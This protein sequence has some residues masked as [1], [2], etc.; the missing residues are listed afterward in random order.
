MR[1]FLFTS[2]GILVLGGCSVAPYYGGTYGEKTPK[3]AVVHADSFEYVVPVV[4]LRV[5]SDGKGLV[6]YEDFG[7]GL[8]RGRVF[9]VR[10]GPSSQKQELLDDLRQFGGAPAQVTVEGK[11]ISTRA[12]DWNG[13]PVV[14]HL[15][16]VPEIGHRVDERSKIVERE[17]TWTLGMI[18]S[19]GDRRYWLSLTSTDEF[20][21]DK[22]AI[23]GRNVQSLCVF[24]NGFRA[25]AK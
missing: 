15:L 6:A 17:R 21:S 9:V 20:F 3:G 1:R 14:F 24:A 11:L 10:A 7:P 13:I 4:S 5:H 2:I 19:A 16:E 23:G 22:E 18:I 12:G 8:G 25:T